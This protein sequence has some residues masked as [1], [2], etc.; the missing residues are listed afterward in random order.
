M[1]YLFHWADKDQYKDRCKTGSKL[2]LLYIARCCG[3][4][5]QSQKGKG[6][7]HVAEICTGAEKNLSMIDQEMG[8]SFSQHSLSMVMKRISN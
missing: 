7:R 2:C 4:M 6:L 5:L 8:V 1:L 3:R